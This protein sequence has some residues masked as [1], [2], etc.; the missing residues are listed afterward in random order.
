MKFGI[1]LFGFLTIELRLL[2]ID[3]TDGD[4]MLGIRFAWK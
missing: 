1:K 4:V 2:D 3:W